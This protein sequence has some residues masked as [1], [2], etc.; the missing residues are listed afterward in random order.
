MTTKAKVGKTFAQKRPER[1]LRDVAKE[2]KNDQKS[3]GI[4]KSFTAVQKATGDGDGTGSSNGLFIPSGEQLAKINEF[5]QSTKSAE[6]VICFSTL[7]CNDQLDRDLDRF[8]A[9][10]VEDFAKLPE[11][12]S[13]VGKGYMVSH[14]Y[15]KLPVGTVFEVGTEN[16]EGVKH[17]TNS[18]FMPNTEQYK[19]FIEN[20]DFGIYRFVSVGVMLDDSACTVCSSPMVGNYWTFCLENGHEKGLWYD[21]NSDEKDSWGWAEPV[22]EGTKGAV[23]C[24]RDLFTPKDFYELSQ[25][26]LGAQYGAQLERSAVGKGIVKGLTKG[27]AKSKVPMLGISVKEAAELPVPIPHINPRVREAYDKGLKILTR[28]A[29]SI[30]W[31]D[32]QDL[33]W[34][35]DAEE[36]EVLCLGEYK[37]AGD[38]TTN[39]EGGED[40]GEPGSEQGRQGEQDDDADSSGSDGSIGESDSERSAD[41]DESEGD[42]DE[43]DADAEAVDP[44]DDSDEDDSEDDESEDDDEDEEDD[45]DVD[46]EAKSVVAAVTKAKLPKSVVDAVKAAK[47]D[48]ALGVLLS[49]VS[50]ALA[51]RDKEIKELEPKA[52]L[53]KQFV[54]AKKAEAVKWYVR[55]RQAGEEKGVNT[56]KFQRMLDRFDD[57]IDLLDEVI[58]EQKQM[59]QAKFPASVRRSAEPTN[60]HDKEALKPPTLSPEAAEKVRKAHG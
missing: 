34:T 16:I 29:S 17:L 11:P 31:V 30:E 19:N 26:F 43:A 1:S 42:D 18:V 8:T 36:D 49:S 3:K 44:D 52:K 35:F 13:S 7:S 50:K 5:T 25:V 41:E 6:D 38:D 48:K 47:S 28:D 54:E 58:E 60:P 24:T 32:D 59:A 37:E 51:D 23:L 33:V 22:A 12:Y 9:E 57:D 53:G 10:C 45:E 56:D 46:E 27:M 20:I 14:D 39:N 15:T 2:T 4:N 55:S 40:N 21:P